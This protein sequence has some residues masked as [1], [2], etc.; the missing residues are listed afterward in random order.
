LTAADGG[1]PADLARAPKPL[2]ELRDG[3]PSVIDSPAVLAG[4]VVRFA[5]GTG[6]VAIDA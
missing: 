4:T 2:L 1:E 5:G 6:P 3:L